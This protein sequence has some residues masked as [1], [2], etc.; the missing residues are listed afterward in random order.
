MVSFRWGAQNLSFDDG[1]TYNYIRNQMREFIRDGDR[2]FIVSLRKALKSVKNEESG[3]NELK[4]QLKKM[5]DEVLDEPLEPVLKKEA[6]GWRRF[7]QLDGKPNEKNLSFIKDKKVKDITD[8]EVLG[9]LKGAGITSYIKRGELD[10]P[11]FNFEDWWKSQRISLTD[12]DNP[13][14]DLRFRESEAEDKE[15]IFSFAHKK[16]FSSID[17][18]IQ[19]RFPPVTGDDVIEAKAEYLLDKTGQKLRPNVRKQTTKLFEDVLDYSFKLP[20]EIPKELRR[21]GKIIVQEQ[22]KAERG[23]EPKDYPFEVVE[24]KKTT[25]KNPV[26]NTAYLRGI[27]SPERTNDMKARKIF[28]VGKRF[29]KIL[30]ADSE[31][32]QTVV[33]VRFTLNSQG[34][35]YSFLK[36]YEDYFFRILKPYFNSPT[37]AYTATILG[38]IKTKA[39]PKKSFEER[40][41]DD[42]TSDRKTS[43]DYFVGGKKLSAK[44]IKEIAQN[45]FKHKTEKTADGE[46]V[47]ISE[48]EYS[49]LSNEEKENYLPDVRIYEYPQTEEVAG[50]AKPKI[51]VTEMTDFGGMRYTTQDITPENVDEAFEK[52][53][54][55]VTVNLIRHATFNLNPFRQK[56]GNRPMTTFTNK[57][58]KNVRELKRRLGD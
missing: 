57:L 45:A 52:A 17:A 13:Q 16:E 29:Y 5:M 32:K 12:E 20:E 41:I 58:K 11:E 54:V 35:P 21:E 23:Y 27:S 38:N 33:S 9:R 25:E 39:N 42:T 7:S 28:S 50:V 36:D 18:H 40:A 1:D 24:D 51:K 22:V 19:A 31:G 55:E 4:T 48:K 47:R 53:Y 8:G 3:L 44:D 26:G 49:A 56:F 14:H 15:G 43:K 2:S 6:E 37:V 34:S 30:S 10:I 46:P